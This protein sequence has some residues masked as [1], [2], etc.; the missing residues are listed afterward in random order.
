M[1]KA[2]ARSLL[3]TTTR[4]Q[5]PF[6]RFQLIKNDADS[7]ELRLNLKSIKKTD[8]ENTSLETIAS[9]LKRLE[10]KLEKLGTQGGVCVPT[11][12][13][14]EQDMEVDL[15]PSAQKG[16]GARRRPSLAVR[17]NE[18]ETSL[19]NK[20]AENCEGSDYE[21]GSQNAEQR[22]KLLKQNQFSPIH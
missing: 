21:S 9:G 3:N 18:E 10:S 14:R 1:A 7:N 15:S 17:E 2:A 20:N 11:N 12:G 8:E 13:A 19:K 4:L 22:G 5:R 16:V 6:H